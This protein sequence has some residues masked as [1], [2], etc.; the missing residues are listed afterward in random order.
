MHY[1]RICKHWKTVGL[2]LHSSCKLAFALLLCTLP[3]HAASLSLGTGNDWYT[4]GLGYN[5][6]DGLSFG[7]EVQLSLDSGLSIQLDALAYTDRIISQ[8]RFDVMTASVSYP[9]TFH[10][11]MLETVIS[12]AVGL[13]IT[14]NLG[15][16]DIQNSY[17]DLIGRDPVLLAYDD[18]TQDT[19]PYLSLTA[20]SGHFFDSLFLGL[21]LDAKV[22]PTWEYSISSSMYFAYHDILTVQLGYE[23]KWGKNLYPT[24]KTQEERYEGLKLGYTYDGGLLQTFYTTYLTSGYSYG[25]FAFDVLSFSVPKTF[26]QNDFSFSTGFL[27]DELGQQSRLFAFSFGNVSFETQHKNGPMFNRMEDQADR[28]NIGLWTIAY[29]MGPENTKSLAL[30]Y[31]KL[32][33]GLQRFNLQQDYTTTLSEELRPIVGLEVGLRIGKRGQWVS[34]NQSYRFRLATSVHYVLFHNTIPKIADFEEHTGP[35]LFRFGLVI[36]VEHD[37]TN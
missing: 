15:F 5:Q 17:H 19:H 13:T 31:A 26:K 35:L 37:L 28:L 14:G 18:C 16:Q 7:A 8:R 6:D 10:T 34:G 27:Y 24:Q 12:P 32:L 23:E 29:Q 2:N 22:I 30:P 4:M 33:A 36:D 20:I 3:L 25:G 9:F 21:G 1:E 11:T